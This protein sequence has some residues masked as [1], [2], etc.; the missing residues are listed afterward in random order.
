MLTRDANAILSPTHVNKLTRGPSGW[1][2][3]GKTRKP[4]L[5]LRVSVSAGKLLLPNPRGSPKSIRDERPRAT[6]R[7]RV[8]DRLAQRE[9]DIAVVKRAIS[10]ARIR[11]DS[12]R[13][14]GETR[15]TAR[16]SLKCTK[17]LT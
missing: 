10:V 6:A 16:Q 9:G 14:S 13:K 1:A 7:G 4:I 2:F 12:R 5:R 3:P 8:R 15:N 11:V 17:E